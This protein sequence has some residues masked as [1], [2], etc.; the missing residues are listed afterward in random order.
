MIS[1]TCQICN[2][3]FAFPDPLAGR[4]QECT[5]CKSPILIPKLDAKS[6]AEYVLQ[7]VGVAGVF[8]AGLLIALGIIVSITEPGVNAGFGL[9]GVLL[10]VGLLLNCA[11]LLGASEAVGY[12]RRI[13]DWARRQK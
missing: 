12:L 8:V 6:F 11:L 10:G 5:K 7:G 1:G 9:G 2:E 4:I 3:P 13:A